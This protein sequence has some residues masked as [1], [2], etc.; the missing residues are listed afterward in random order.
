[1]TSFESIMEELIEIVRQSIEKVCFSSNANN[2][3]DFSD[4]LITVGLVL[5]PGFFC[6]ILAVTAP[7]RELIVFN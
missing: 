3:I 5:I 2:N 1:M 4:V 6:T 7:H